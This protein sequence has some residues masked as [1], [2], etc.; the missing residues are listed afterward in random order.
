MALA[1]IAAINLDCDEP[2]ALAEFWA[3]LLG[4]TVV[5]QS[6]D[7]CAVQAGPLVIGAIRVDGHRRPTWPSGDVPQQ[8][9]LDLRVDDLNSAAE[10]AIRLG[11]S[12]GPKQF[13]PER[14]RVL[15]DPAGHPFCLRA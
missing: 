4:G 15:L 11:A 12:D 6:P 14:S 3:H 13:T 5:M 8:I 9:H 10:E 7:F 2:G 1:E